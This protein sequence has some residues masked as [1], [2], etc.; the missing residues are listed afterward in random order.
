[1]RLHSRTDGRGLLTAIHREEHERYGNQRRTNREQHKKPLV[2]PADSL[3][4]PLPV[5]VFA[6]NA[7]EQ[8][9]SQLNAFRAM[10]RLDAQQAPAD[11]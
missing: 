10:M 8:I 5:A 2:L 1:L 6:H 3:P 7:G 9:V 4:F 11:Q